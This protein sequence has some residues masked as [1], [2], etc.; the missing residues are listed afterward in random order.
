MREYQLLADHFG[1]VIRDM[2]MRRKVPEI[3]FAQFLG[4]PPQQLRKIEASDPPIPVSDGILL[5]MA[6]FFDKIEM[7]ERRILILG[8]S[9][10]SAG[11]MK[12]P[13]QNLVKSLRNIPK[14]E[15]ALVPQVNGYS[16]A[17]AQDLVVLESAL[18]EF[19]AILG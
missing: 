15:Y 11:E 5:K 3:W 12:P 13:H 9:Q 14:K 8:E 18:D 16:L 2:R 4:I 19:L 6:A 1:P 10:A 7:G 17:L